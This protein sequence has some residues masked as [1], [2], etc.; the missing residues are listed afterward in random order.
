M[1]DHRDFSLGGARAAAAADDLAAWVRDFL[2]SDG[3][4]NAELGHHLADTTRCWIGPVLLPFSQLHRLAGPA[5]D[6][7]L[8]PVEEHEWRDDVAELADKIDEGLEPPPV[9]VSAR[10]DQLVLED[11]NHRVEALRQAGHRRSWAVIGFDDVGARDR[12]IERSEAA[13]T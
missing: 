7:V 6:P 5:G 9:V 8:C 11:G 12:F 4:D 2:G 10:G 13:A 3:S 1:T